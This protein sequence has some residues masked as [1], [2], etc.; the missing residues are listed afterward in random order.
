M[1]RFLYRHPS[2]AGIFERPYRKGKVIRRR[3]QILGEL[4]MGSYGIAYVANDLQTGRKVVVKQYRKT[5]GKG[6]ELSFQ[7]EADILTR[8]KHPQIPALY[9]T[10]LENGTPHLV[11]DYIEGETVETLIFEKGKTYTEREAFQLLR[12]VLA[13]VEYIHANNIVHRDLRIPNI[14]L[15]DGT[16]FVIDFGLARFFGES[17]PHIETYVPEKSCGAIFIQKAT[18]TR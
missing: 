10:F 17:V 18:F 5:R 6:S 15:R 13:V 14:L 11:M 7:W 4:G 1:M 16:V 2:F 3:Y 9:D 8:L 12:D